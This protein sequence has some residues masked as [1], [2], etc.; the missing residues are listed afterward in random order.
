MKTN[1]KGSQ[2][3]K[4][5]NRLEEELLIGR[6]A[7]GE[8]LGERSIAERFG[9]S[10]TPVREALQRLAAS[11]LVNL[12]GRQGARVV[13][14]SVPD[15]LDAFYVVAELEAMAAFQASRR[16]RPD[17]S[18]KLEAFEV[19]CAAKAEKG[20]PEGFYIENLQF[21]YTIV[22]S[23]NNWVLQKQL[24]SVRLMTSAYRRYV[25]YQ[26]G[27]MTISV[28]EHR[29]I[30]QEILRGNG[31]KAAEL[32]RQHINL[33]GESVSDF[34]HFLNSSGEAPIEFPPSMFN[35]RT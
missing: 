9:V 35:S 2:V 7:P 27:R 10:R 28:E 15:M 16:I 5:V 19:A 20:D 1:G 17:Q 22:E 8:R 29:A 30:M 24:R 26:P 23:C 32:M 14:L 31:D 33:L 3:D 4:I 12:R 11:S 6:L 34:L 13:Q 25:T 18:K 21:H